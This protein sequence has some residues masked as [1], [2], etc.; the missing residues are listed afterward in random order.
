MTILFCLYSIVSYNSGRRNGQVLVVLFELIAKEIIQSIGS[1]VSSE[2]IERSLVDHSHMTE[3]RTGSEHISLIVI[4]TG[5]GIGRRG[6]NH[7]NRAIVITRSGWVIIV[8]VIIIVV[9]VWRKESSAGSPRTQSSSLLLLFLLLFV[10]EHRNDR[11]P[12]S[13]ELQFQFMEITLTME[14]KERE[15]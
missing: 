6:K 4:V 11:S 7:R 15:K 14:K 5:T 13:S 8:I 12:H 10:T 1:V 3:A 2:D 9:I